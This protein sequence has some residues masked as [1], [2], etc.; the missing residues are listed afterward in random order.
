MGN[1]IPARERF[2]SETEHRQLEAWFSQ[3]VPSDPERG[4]PGAAE[5]EAADFVDF[6]LALDGSVNSELPVWR[7]LYR[8]GLPALSAECVTSLGEPPE[9][10][11]PAQLVSVLEGLSTG[12]LQRVPASI[13]QVRLFDMM[14]THCIE[15]CFSDPRWGGNRDLVIWRWYGYLHDP[16][17]AP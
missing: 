8:S 15:G 13:D 4:V 12:S 16:K 1:L 14:R 3:L 6:L 11:H 17:P 10:L 9:A 5:A 2:F 7:L